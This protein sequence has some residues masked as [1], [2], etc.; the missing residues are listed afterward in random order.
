MPDVLSK[1]G[2]KEQNP[3]DAETVRRIRA[4]ILEKQLEEQKV[5]DLEER[6]AK[7]EPDEPE[8]KTS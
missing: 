4:Y 7:E 3:A 5:I 2:V 1:A 8:S 6:I